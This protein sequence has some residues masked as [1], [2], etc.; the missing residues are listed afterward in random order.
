MEKWCTGAWKTNKDG[1]KAYK[2]FYQEISKKI[3]VNFHKVK[4][5]SGDRYND[6]ADI[7]AKGALGI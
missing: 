4:G 5:H 3:K 1:T 7:L 2:A 6:E